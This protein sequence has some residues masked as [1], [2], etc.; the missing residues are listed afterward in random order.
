[1]QATPHSFFQ[2]EVKKILLKSMKP[3]LAKTRQLERLRKERQQQRAE[4]NQ[5]AICLQP[6]FR[7]CVQC[8]NKFRSHKFH[9]KCIQEAFPTGNAHCP[10]C[11]QEINQ[12]RELRP[13]QAI[14]VTPESL[15]FDNNGPFEFV[16][17]GQSYL[18]R[19]GTGLLL[20]QPNATETPHAIPISSLPRYQ[21]NVAIF[22]LGRVQRGDL[23]IDDGIIWYRHA[24]QDVTNDPSANNPTLSWGATSDT[25]RS[26]EANGQLVL[27]ESRSGDPVI[28]LGNG[29]EAPVENYR[30]T[31]DN[32]CCIM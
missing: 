21:T 17:G 22:W 2:T 6:C 8:T 24:E 3:A 12:L 5:C 29:L 11:K 14:N 26:S 32:S 30:R 16:E 1:M 19:L 27:A 18:E 13:R 4:D 9:L 15:Q 25:V 10:I 20:L 31:Q 7:V 28:Y 23:W